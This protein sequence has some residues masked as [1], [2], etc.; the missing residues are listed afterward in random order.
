VKK[1]RAFA[2]GFFQRKSQYDL[3]AER[4]MLAFSRDSVEFVKHPN[5]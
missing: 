1:T 3:K 2:R 4:G 5:D